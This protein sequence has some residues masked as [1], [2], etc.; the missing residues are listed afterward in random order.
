[1]LDYISNPQSKAVFIFNDCPELS[2]SFT[3]MPVDL[4]FAPVDKIESTGGGC[5]KRGL[6]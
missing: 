3:E 6:I 2:L 5:L 1:M 4:R